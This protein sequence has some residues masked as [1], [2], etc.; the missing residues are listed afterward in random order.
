[1]RA[2]ARRILCSSPEMPQ[3][4]ANIADDDMY[5]I[6]QTPCEASELMEAIEEVWCGVWG[7]GCGV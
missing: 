6:G 2:R 3:A 1:M 4:D 7:V 5:D